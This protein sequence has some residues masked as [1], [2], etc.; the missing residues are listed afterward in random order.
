MNHLK[1]LTKNTIIDKNTL[2]DQFNEIRSRGYSTIN[3]E[4]L[5][6]LNA[7]GAPIFNYKK[8]EVVGAVSFDFPADTNPIAFILNEYADFIKKLSTDLSELVTVA[9]A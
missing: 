9:D 7:I 2:H 4:Y 6:G 1:Q 3:E 8:N 5:P